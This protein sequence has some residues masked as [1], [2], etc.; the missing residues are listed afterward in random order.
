MCRGSMVAC[1]DLL[2][3]VQIHGLQTPTVHALQ[4]VNVLQV[5]PMEGR[6][7]SAG[8]SDARRGVRRGRGLYSMRGCCAGPYLRGASIGG[9]FVVLISCAVQLVRLLQVSCCLIFCRWCAWAA[10][11]AAPR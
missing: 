8:G 3:V 4:V 1:F 11:L 5:G 6:E 7:S 10:S 2:Q 9:V